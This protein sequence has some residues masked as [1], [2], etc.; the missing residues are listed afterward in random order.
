VGAGLGHV[1]FIRWKNQNRG[2]AAG[3]LVVRRGSDGTD[4][5]PDANAD[6]H[7]HS[8][9][10]EG[11]DAHADTDADE[12]ADA[13]ADSHSNT[14]ADGH[15]DGD[16]EAAA[17]T[18]AHAHQGADAYSDTD[19]DEAADANADA[20]A[21]SEAD[22]DSD[23]V[24]VD[25]RRDGAPARG[26]DSSSV[27]PPLSAVRHGAT[28]RECPK[29]P[30]RGCCGVVDQTTNKLTGYLAAVSRKLEQPLAAIIQSSSS[31]GAATN[32]STC[33]RSSSLGSIRNRV[34]TGPPS[35][36]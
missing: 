35:V 15:S 4:A 5:D 30:L 32:S 26:R 29:R 19:A 10:D 7:A 16:Q 22:E 9:S 13:N 18:D 25:R 24:A 14:A 28:M 2:P 3:R 34:H 12:A 17:H 20:D 33:S 8:D 31:A 6:P 1:R 21:H 11:P 36:R 23:P 27:V